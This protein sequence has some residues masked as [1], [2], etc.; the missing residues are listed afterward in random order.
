MH[1]LNAFCKIL[2]Y[3]YCRALQW[4]CHCKNDLFSVSHN[5][6]ITMSLEE[7]ALWKS[8]LRLLGGIKSPFTTLHGKKNKVKQHRVWNF[9]W[10][11]R[12]LFWAEIGLKWYIT[13]TITVFL[14][15]SITPSSSPTMHF[16]G[17]VC[18][19]ESSYDFIKVWHPC[20]GKPR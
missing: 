10:D 12:L 13:I 16:K 20:T 19:A 4:K 14:K 7:V 15:V 3:G 11:K 8:F 1:K 6:E 18:P 5:N 2:F 9:L 17:L